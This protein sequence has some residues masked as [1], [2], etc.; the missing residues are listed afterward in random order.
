M[1]PDVT[2]GDNRAEP[3]TSKSDPARSEQVDKSKLPFSSQFFVF[4]VDEFDGLEALFSLGDGRRGE[5]DIIAKR[6]MKGKQ[7]LKK[8][9][10][11]GLQALDNRL[12]EGF[13]TV[14]HL[15]N[16][17]KERAFRKTRDIT[18]LAPEGF[19]WTLTAFASE[20][21]MI[22]KHSPFSASPRQALMLSL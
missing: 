10:I 3:Q 13:D 9:M 22:S 18:L 7:E 15:D 21:W 17:N 11:R 6:D 14:F 16:E 2:H 5:G 19:W 8:F 12:Y 20:L 4:A 1:A